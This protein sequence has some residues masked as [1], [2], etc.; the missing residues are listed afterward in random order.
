MN[1]EA[2][3]DINLAASLIQTISL[4]AAEAGARNETDRERSLN[5][6]AAVMIKDYRARYP[7]NLVLLQ[8]ECDLVA[9]H[10]DFTRA[11]EL[12]REMDKAS[13]TSP[14]GCLLRARLYTMLGRTA[15]R[16]RRPTPKHSSETPASSMSA[17]CSGRPSSA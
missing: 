3:E 14:A 9:R 7:D 1:K 17:S 4:Q 5:E 8:I 11:I 10:G 16:R 2:P 15:R 12:T 6:K 13:K